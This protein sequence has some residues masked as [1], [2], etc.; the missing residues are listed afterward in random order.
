MKK[1]AGKGSLFLRLIE[2][3]TGGNPFRRRVQLIITALSTSSIRSQ[4][5]LQLS[6]RNEWKD[7]VGLLC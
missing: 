3:A 7:V 6:Q 4:L 1:G 5:S 2:L